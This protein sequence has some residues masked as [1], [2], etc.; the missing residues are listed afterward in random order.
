MSKPLYGIK[1]N[2]TYEQEN[3]L[4]FESFLDNYFY[5]DWREKNMRSFEIIISPKCNL[6]CSYCYINKYNN[7]L[8]NKTQSTDNVLSNIDYILKFL[9]NKQFTG[10]LNL[11]SGELLSQQLGYD[12]LE[13]IYTFYK[14]K[15]REKKIKLICIPTNYTFICDEECTSKVQDLIDRFRDIGINLFLSASF[16]G[17]KVETYRP[18]KEDLDFCFK[19]NYRTDD[20]Y[21]KVFAFMKKNDFGPHPMIYNK[22]IFNW[23]ENFDWFQS[24]LEKYDM[25]WWNLYL[26]QVRNN[27]WTKEQN[28]EMYNFI[29]YI[30]DFS[31]K[32]CDNN[33]EKL[34]EFLKKRKGFNILTA[35]F[36]KTNRGTTCGLQ[37]NLCIR[38]EDLKTFSCHRLMY[39]DFIICDWEKDEEVG[40]KPI[41]KNAE[42]GITTY[43]C[44][45]KSFPICI[46]CP[47]KELCNGGCLGAQYESTGSMFTPIPNVC[48][49]YYYLI[50]AV[51]DGFDEIG[52][53]EKFI[54]YANFEQ[55]KAIEI[56]RSINL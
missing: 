44:N 32:K 40:L 43:G 8:F 36:F 30:I 11:F 38:A 22:A 29:R 37:L 49:N 27:G 1:S 2:A 19:E 35:P 24:M 9:D 7:K 18:Y 16:D 41:V 13:K 39:E 47:I 34:L 3:Q 23:K 5:S 28:Q 17:K 15:P 14:D 46:E 52:I 51:I 45:T 6:G 55:R 54:D 25:D 10:E 12:L 4:L 50:K 56:L 33:P 53:T 20:Y 48:K 42:L 26:L 31:L 21:E